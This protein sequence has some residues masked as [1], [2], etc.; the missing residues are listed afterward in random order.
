M[1][2]VTDYLFALGLGLFVA[3]IFSFLSAIPT[4]FLWNW[5]CPQLFHLPI[6]TFFQAWGIGWLCMILFKSNGAVSKS[7]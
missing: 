5:L 1:K 2:A 7:E 4:Y 6:I 3:L